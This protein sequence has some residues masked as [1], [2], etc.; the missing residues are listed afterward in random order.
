VTALDDFKLEVFF[1]RWEFTARHHLTASDMETMRLADLLALAGPE[2]LE[3]WHA[4]DLGYRPT[5][6]DADLREAIAGT[7]AHVTP[8]QVLC[9]AGAQEGIACTL[10]ALLEPGDHAIVVTPNYQ[11]P[12]SIARS[13]CEVSGVPLDEDRGFALDLDAVAAALRPG[14]RLIAVNF[15]N[16]PTG[17]VPDPA[18]FAE[19]AEL[20][21]GLGIWLFSD[22]VY[23][24]IEQ[25]PAAT[26]PQAA[27]LSDRALSLGVMSKA[28]GMPGLRVGWVACR[29]HDLLERIERAKH[30][31]SICNAGPSEVLARI[32]LRAGPQILE[33]NRTLVRDNLVLFDAFFAE[34]AD[35]FEWAH[36]QGGCVCFPRY[37]GDEGAERF[38]ADLLEQ[39]GVLLLPPSIYASLLSPTPTDRFRLGVGRRDPG[40]A[41]EALGRYLGD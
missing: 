13:I 2:E 20:A 6:G 3:A 14:T 12:E 36:P 37:L 21:G 11:S 33:R 10:R 25:D 19:L 32:A 39:E 40:P 5:W 41:L 38:C 30:Y 31:G 7:Y 29:D 16:N 24:G 18:V 35:R 9:F 1:S 17:A 4:L 26:L 23:R 22:E 8:D 15:P 27:D 34:H 28:Y